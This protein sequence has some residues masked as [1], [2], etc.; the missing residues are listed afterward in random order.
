MR[1]PENPVPGPARDFVGYGREVP[2][3]VWPN[4]A[5]VAVSLVVNYEEG[6]EVHLAAVGRNE[7]A[8]GEIPYVMDPA[9]RDLAI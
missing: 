6:S 5:R 4:E 2:K 7:A 8:L 3:V 1:M 9:H